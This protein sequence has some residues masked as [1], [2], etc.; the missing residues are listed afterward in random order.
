MKDMWSEFITHTAKMVLHYR[1]WA[2]DKSLR[3]ETRLRFDKEAARYEQRMIDYANKWM[4][5]S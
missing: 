1:E 4:Q 3:Y 2:N 5:P